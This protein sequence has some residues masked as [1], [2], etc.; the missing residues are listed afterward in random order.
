MSLEK[1][2]ATFSALNKE[3]QMSRAEVE[4]K[5]IWEGLFDRNLNFGGFLIN[6]VGL[7]GSGKTSILHH[8]KTRIMREHPEEI[9]IWREPAN[10]PLQAINNG[11]DVQILYDTANPIKLQE[12]TKDGLIE[13]HRYALHEFSTID[14]LFKLLKPGVINVIYMNKQKKW[15]RL[16][17]RA[18]MSP[19][20]YSIFID[21]S[22]DI[23]PAYSKDEMWIIMER[24]GSSVKSVRKGLVSMWLDTQNES[25][26]DYRISSKI[27][28]SIYLYG[29]R[30]TVHSPVWK[31]SLQNLEVGSGWID[32]GGRFGLINYGPVTPKAPLYYI[33]DDS[34]DLDD[35]EDHDPDLRKRA[36][37]L[38]KQFSRLIDDL[39]KVEDAIGSSGADDAK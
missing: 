7:Q 10:K 8:A 3:E 25:D 17:N 14:E 28:V 1:E 11:E 16:I 15:I 2:T 5:K 9:I 29:S 13:S 6:I 34:M 21:E 19:G 35:S 33:I 12:M 24:F 37:K 36:K 38:K 39:A 32:Y 23:F 30:K 26:L 18:V 31:E 4:G 27:M 22:E 20:W